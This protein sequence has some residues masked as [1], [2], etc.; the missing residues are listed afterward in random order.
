MI[1]TVT[2]TVPYAGHDRSVTGS[3]EA[4]AV[5]S[6]LVVSGLPEIQDYPADTDKV[7]GLGIDEGRIEGS[8][9]LIS[10]LSYVMSPKEQH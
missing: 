1:T 5:V 10:A 7:A 2:Y 6:L 8:P 4:I 3:P 9:V